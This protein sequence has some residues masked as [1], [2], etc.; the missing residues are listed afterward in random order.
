[1][2]RNRQGL[3]CSETARV[4]LAPNGASRVMLRGFAFGIDNR[5][6]RCGVSMLLVSGTHYDFQ[7]T[8]RML[9]SE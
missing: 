2:A 4:L 7:S 9:V 8:S 6:G 5:L 1:M 3:S